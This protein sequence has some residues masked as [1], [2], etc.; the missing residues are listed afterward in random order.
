MTPQNSKRKRGDKAG[1]GPISSPACRR[2][3]QS[4]RSFALSPSKGSESDRSSD[5]VFEQIS[6]VDCPS[7]PKRARFNVARRIPQTPTPD[8]QDRNIVG[9]PSKHVRVP[10]GRLIDTISVSSE[11]EH[12]QGSIF[13]RASSDQKSGGGSSCSSFLPSPP[14]Q[15]DILVVSDDNEQ[16]A[17]RPSRGDIDH[18]HTTSTDEDDIPIT[19]LRRKHDR[20]DSDE[21]TGS[22]SSEHVTEE[23]ASAVDSEDSYDLSSMLSTVP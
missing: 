18:H 17:R 10:A 8:P 16:P 19:L 5:V 6:E 2:R 9:S 12:I 1:I 22:M 4:L 11:D 13:H 15:R 7:P 21:D 20:I 23:Q 3:K 14:T